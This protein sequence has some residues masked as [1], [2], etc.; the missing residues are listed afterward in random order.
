[1]LTRAICFVFVLALLAGGALSQPDSTS[2][3][4]DTQQPQQQQTAPEPGPAED[5]QQVGRTRN[6]NQGQA[7][8]QKRESWLR[9]FVD[10]FEEHHNFWI[11]FST[12][13]I[14]AF[15]VALVFS[16]IGL[17]VATNRAAATAEKALLSLEGP[18]L[19]LV[20]VK[21]RIFPQAA[22]DRLYPGSAP[23][24]EVDFF[25]FN[26]GRSTAI[27]QRIK[28]E[29]MLL[30]SDPPDPDFTDKVQR[31]SGVTVIAANVKTLPLTCKFHR[32][33]TADELERL[34]AGS[35]SLYLM[36]AVTYGDTLGYR[37]NYVFFSKFIPA[38]S[39][40]CKFVAFGHKNHH[41]KEKLPDPS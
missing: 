23:P 27:V 18:M 30:E 40:E 12:V 41:H 35:L 4:Q 1:M 6:E 16:T 15:T 2:Q 34:R 32:S 26:T 22:A 10:F 29:L 19:F 20:D 33:L 14:A 25:L 37:N 17:W 3:G 8:E 39:S 24:P 9:S 28:S 31:R 5:A 13:I 21:D 11:A 36:G 7:D 38:I